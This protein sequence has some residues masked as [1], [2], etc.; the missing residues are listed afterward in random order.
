MNIREKAFVI[1]LSFARTITEGALSAAG[2]FFLLQGAPMGRQSWMAGGSGMC[3]VAI[4]GEVYAQNIENAVQY[5]SKK[6]NLWCKLIRKML[7]DLHDV[8]YPPES[9]AA[10]KPYKNSFLERYVKNY[11]DLL[12]KEH[13]LEHLL[14]EEVKDHAAINATKEAI[15]KNFY[16]AS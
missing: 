13:D 14:E 2:V 11:E 6:N 3:A 4:E 9:D 15:E 16:K 8:H 5:R 12:Q 1:P 7:I 10:K